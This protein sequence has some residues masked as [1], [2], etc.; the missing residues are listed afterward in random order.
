M[1]VFNKDKTV[2]SRGVRLSYK[3]SGTKSQQQSNLYVLAIGT[4]DYLGDD[5]DLRF[6]AKDAED[7]AQVMGLT[8]NTALFPDHHIQVLST[9]AH[10][11]PPTKA[12]IVKAFA[13]L[14]DSFCGPLGRLLWRVKNECQGRQPGR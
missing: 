7:F 4:S 9:S 2:A 6:A 14:Q 3:A 5:L 10:Q 11:K 12:N 13:A 8:A 1:V